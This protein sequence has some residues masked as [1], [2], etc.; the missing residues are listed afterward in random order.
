MRHLLFSLAILM[1]L[2]C[3][4]SKKNG[5]F[6]V[7]TPFSKN[8]YLSDSETYRSVQS[9]T[10]TSEIMSKKIALVNAKVELASHISSHVESAGRQYIEENMLN[11]NDTIVNR[12]WEVINTTVNQHL[13]H[14]QIIGEKTERNAN[15]S[16]TTWVAIEMK[17]EILKN[18]LKEKFRLSPNLYG[19]SKGFDL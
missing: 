3:G 16:Y 12:F 2:A 11:D 13:R 1:P 18:E 7:E 5:E 19:N 9:A 10:N 4:V 15:G 8:T 17:K 6:I 14:I